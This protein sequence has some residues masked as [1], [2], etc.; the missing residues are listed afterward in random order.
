[1]TLPNINQISKI[2]EFYY[3]S[4]SDLQSLVMLSEV[5]HQFPTEKGYRVE[6]FFSPK[7]LRVS[8][9]KEEKQNDKEWIWIHQK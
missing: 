8:I 2:R 4:G 6:A 1:M 7:F 9:Y 3:E 5:L